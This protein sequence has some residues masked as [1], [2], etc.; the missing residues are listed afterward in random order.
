[1][2]GY[3]YIYIYIPHHRMHEKTDDDTLRREGGYIVRKDRIL[4]R[5]EADNLEG[6]R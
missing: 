5:L 1:M 4:A 2:V 3:V 6:C